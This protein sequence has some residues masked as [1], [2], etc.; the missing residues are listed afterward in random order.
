MA[1]NINLKK[2]RKTAV[3]KKYAK[4]QITT[5]WL[6]NISNVGKNVVSLKILQSRDKISYLALH[7]TLVT[8]TLCRNLQKHFN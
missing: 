5:S 8:K 2:S 3:Y 4:E 6:K 1:E 7:D